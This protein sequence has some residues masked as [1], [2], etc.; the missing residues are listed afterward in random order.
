MIER[1]KI[2]LLSSIIWM[3]ICFVYDIPAALNNMIDYGNNK[4][5]EYKLTVLYSAYAFPN[6]IMPLAFGWAATFNIKRVSRFLCC[7]VFIGHLIFTLGIYKTSFKMMVCGRLILGIGGESFSVIQNKLIS[8]EFKG[9]DLSFAMGLFSSVARL[10]TILN[11]LITPILSHYFNPKLP[12]FIGLL[13]TLNGTLICFYLNSKSRGD[14]L[15]DLLIITQGED[16]SKT[17]STLKPTNPV[18]E[19]K[20]SPKLD[21][22]INVKANGN[23]K[24]RSIF[25]NS[26]LEAS[27]Y[28]PWE[29][30][31][32]ESK[33]AAKL[34]LKKSEPK[35]L[36]EEKNVLFFEPNLSQEKGF[37]STFI[38][39]VL[40]SFTF[41]IIWAPF[42][43][44]A[45]LLFQKRYNMNSID[46]GHILAIIETMGLFLSP[47]V[48]TIA[49]KIGY[50]LIFVLF[51]SII[52][53]VSHIL[54]Y[55]NAVSPYIAIA[56]L[57]MSGPMVNC[58][59]PCIPNLVSENNLTKGFA[60]VYCVLNFAF[61][62]SPVL[63][64]MFATKNASYD[65]VEL[66]IIFVAFVSM[67]LIA[68]LVHLNSKYT[69]GL[70]CK[71]VDIK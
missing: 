16:I 23:E 37:H 58:Y 12:C 48:G 70:N 63:V 24:F 55:K 51:G 66:Y 62:F 45:P 27:P 33:E 54:I 13:L 15:K 32:R 6:I 17:V 20:Q 31:A 61:T 46:S 60:A 7:L 65:H 43:A 35:I 26:G 47:I 30:V 50:K 2:L 64:A 19:A 11:F 59:W 52:L 39:L 21:N 53:M 8:S 4:N 42:Y 9:K 38:L 10:G 18:I 25:F 36:Y 49:D 41:A 40:I 57:G 28:S 44:I 5:S 71:A 34:E 67:G 1:Y 14:R 68:L 56:L 29:E 3:G 69:L 22:E